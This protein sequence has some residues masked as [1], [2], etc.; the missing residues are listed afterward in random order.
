MGAG[1]LPFTSAPYPGLRPF[2]A[3]ES[4]IFFGR[5][6]QVDKLLEK[7]QQNRFLALVGASGCGKSSLVRAG[8]IAGLEAGFMGEAGHRWRIADLRP[9]NEEVRGDEMP[10]PGREA[11]RARLEQREGG[12][13][14]DPGDPQ[15]VAHATPLH[16]APAVGRVS[17]ARTG[18][19]RVADPNSGRPSPRLSGGSSTTKE[20]RGSSETPGPT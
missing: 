11:V 10:L 4:D 14:H 20:R 19:M 1:E 8:L 6:E 9:G 5:E 17:R 2:A 12:G 16:G 15:H 18:R 7:L 3:A 13:K